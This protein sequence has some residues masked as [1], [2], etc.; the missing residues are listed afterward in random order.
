M[1]GKTW[2]VVTMVLV[3]ATTAAVPGSGQASDDDEAALAAMFDTRPAPPDQLFR[4]EWTASPARSGRARLEGSVHNGSGHAAL[5]VQLRIS[6]VDE[7]GET[8]RTAVGPT[9][10]RVPGGG[11]VHFDIPVPDR[12]HAYRVAV[13]SF[14]FD[15][16]RPAGR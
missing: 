16:A 8:V 7:T 3:T 2:R 12:R 1:G 13:G 5:N 6:E 9:F 15:F 10:A 11:E 14:S 4:V